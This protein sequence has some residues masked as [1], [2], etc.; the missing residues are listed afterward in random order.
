MSI[1]A[2]GWPTSI[3]DAG[4]GLRAGRF[5]V[6]GLTRHFLDGIKLLQP[7]LNALITVT[8]DLAIT[9]AAALDSELSDGIDRGGLH[10]VPIVIKDDTDVAGVPTSVG[11][12]LYKAQGT[13]RVPERDATVIERLKAAGAV[14]LGKANLNEFAAGGKGGFNP[15][16]GDTGNPWSLG[17]E[18]GGSSSGTGSAVAARLCL[19][20]TGTDAGGSVRG[21]ASRCGIVGIRPTY[22]RVSCR[23]TFPRCRSFG[24]VGPIANRVADVGALLTVMAGHDPRD[25]SS[26]D[27]PQENFAREIPMG[28]RGL[29]LG[30]I[31]EFSLER[32]D[33]EVADAFSGALRVFKA[34]GVE[35]K[36][37][38]A[39]VFSKAL[40]PARLAVIIFHEFAEVIAD[41]YD[42]AE[43]SL[44]GEIVHQDMVKARGEAP[45]NYDQLIADRQQHTRDVANLF[46]KVDCLLTP[47]FPNMHAAVDDPPDLSGDHRRFTVPVSYLGLPSVALPCGLSSDR[48]P[49]G[50]QIIGGWNTETQIIRTAAAFEAA[51]G[52]LG[53]RPPL[54]WMGTNS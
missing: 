47:V 33:P 32:L 5:T 53:E 22:G 46:G 39:P 24:T 9:T 17:H 4:I 36:S 34:L 13:G 18:P 10:G 50:M 44:F 35:V 20:G 26:L 3:A 31:D 49:I 45:G 54:F 38:K 2:D 25:P 51:S 29:R 42:R 16:F 37:V 6:D 19:G 43:P 1:N 52:L 48:L 27:L 28:V 23:G 30:V 8:E 14:I 41:Q 15:H 21:P 12:A 11:S 40:D 7:E